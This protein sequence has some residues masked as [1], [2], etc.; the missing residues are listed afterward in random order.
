MDR[1]IAFATKHRLE[2][3]EA[4]QARRSVVVLGTAADISKAFAVELNDYESPNGTYHSHEG[5]INVPTDVAPMVEAVVGLDNRPVMAT[6]FSTARRQ[7]PADPLNTQPLT[8]QQVAQLY[9][10]P[11]GT[12]KGQTIGI[13]EMETGGGPAGYTSADLTD[14]MKAFGNLKLPKIQDVSVDN[15][16]NSGTSDGETGLDITLAGAIAQDATI[17]VYFTGGTTQSIIHALQKMVHPGSGDPVPTIISISYGWGPD[18]KNGQGLSD[19]DITQIG[20][21]FQDAAAMHITVLVSSGD[22]GAYIADQT[23]A[24]V[25]YPASDPWVTACGGTTI[26]NIQGAT[27]DEYVWNDTGKAGPGATG[28]GVS[29]RFDIPDYQSQANLPTQIVSGQ[30]GRGVPD[31]AGN[32]S[33]NSGYPQYINGQFQAVGGTS[34]VAPLYAG[35]IARI[36]ENLTSPVGFL[37]PK[38]YSAGSGVFRSIS[39]PPGPG[40]NSYGQ[41]K[42]YPA[43]LGWNA[44]TGLGSVHGQALQTLLAPAQA[45]V[46]VQSGQLDPTTA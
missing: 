40:D 20:M 36:N 14:T 2:V 38:L 37:N 3:V 41:V 21:L 18:D 8:P 5:T 17:A 33:E 19:Q 1:V 42:G 22:S 13:Y 29:A 44:C 27:F 7:N 39:S 6:H 43:T 16:G 10:F 12:G 9:G 31:I 35:L 4:N 32:A 24:Q 25:S 23:N 30:R 26:G 28:G 11:G 45:A 15:V 34:A 46:Q